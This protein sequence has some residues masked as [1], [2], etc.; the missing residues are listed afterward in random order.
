VAPKKKQKVAAVSFESFR[1]A[2]AVLVVDTAL[3]RLCWL[4]DLPLLFPPSQ[5]MMISIFIATG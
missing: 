1:F 4:E 3:L 2:A 5:L